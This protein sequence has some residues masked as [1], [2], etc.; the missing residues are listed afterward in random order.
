LGSNQS[1]YGTPSYR[2]T[3]ALA[4]PIYDLLHILA[5]ALH[6]GRRNVWMK[7]IQSVTYGEDEKILDVCCGTGYLESL[8]LDSVEPDVQIVGID[9]SENQIR[10]AKKRVGVPNVQFLTGDARQI[11]FEDDHFEKSF[12]NFALHEMP[13]DVRR[14]VLLEVVRVT[15]KDG[16]IVI[17]EGNR[18]NR[19]LDR[20]LMYMSFFQWWPW[21]VD[22]PHSKEVWRTD[23]VSE[24]ADCGMT[25]VTRGE[26]AREFFQ[27]I[28]AHPST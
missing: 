20:F 18:P 6:G 23:Y 24:L 28:I 26:F 3:Y 7:A 12:I 16:A 19:K 1:K 22:H 25:I 15:K 2:R 27:L 21:C 17:L 10:V 4:A 8:L 13:T 5:F 11:P 9:L 14:A